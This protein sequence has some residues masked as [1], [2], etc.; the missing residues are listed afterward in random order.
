MHDTFQWRK[1]TKKPYLNELNFIVYCSASPASGKLLGLRMTTL[2]EEP[3]S[4]HTLTEDV[5]ENYSDSELN[6]FHDDTAVKKP[7]LKSRFPTSKTMGS[8]R[9][10]GNSFQSMT[11]SSCIT[12]NVTKNVRK[13]ATNAPNKPASGTPSMTS[14]TSSGYGSQ[15]RFDCPPVWNDWHLTVRG[16]WFWF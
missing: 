1:E 8:L 11:S 15:V 10:I 2:H 4:R 13:N 6:Q 12:N 7:P 9:D 16:Y 14:S 5:E 3:S